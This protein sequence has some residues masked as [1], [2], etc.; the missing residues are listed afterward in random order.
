M[1]H[2]AL[3]YINNV[4]I[5][6]EYCYANRPLELPKDT[7]QRKCDNGQDFPYRVRAKV[8]KVSM[9]SRDTLLSQLGDGKTSLIEIRK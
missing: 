5:T 3:N 7:C 4:G 2:S 9:D 6:E 1:V 8:E